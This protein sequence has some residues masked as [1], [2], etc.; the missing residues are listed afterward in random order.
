MKKLSEV[1]DLLIIKG[2]N[3]PTKKDYLVTYKS[4]I[5]HPCT[6]IS[7]GTNNE[8][9]AKRKSKKLAKMMGWETEV[10]FNDLKNKN[11]PTPPPRSAFKTEAAYKA[12][13]RE[14]NEMKNK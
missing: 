1:D 6:R 3:I 9:V 8:V 4:D 10:V 5:P 2:L 13:M 11:T 12:A 14:Y 7:S